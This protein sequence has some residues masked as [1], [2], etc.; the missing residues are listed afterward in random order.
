MLLL[1]CPQNI[2][3]SAYALQHKRLGKIIDS[4]GSSFMSSLRILK[5]KNSLNTMVDEP[6]F[7]K[8]IRKQRNQRTTHPTV[9]LREM[10]WSIY[11]LVCLTAFQT[12]E[13]KQCC[14]CCCWLCTAERL[15][16]KTPLQ[17]PLF[18]WSWWF[19]IQQYL[20][21]TRTT[22]TIIR[23]TSEEQKLCHYF[24]YMSSTV[25]YALSNYTQEWNLLR[26]K[27]IYL[28]RRL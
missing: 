8:S 16:R 21:A 27:M 2:A 22:T 14:C 12:K 17:K 25:F 6:F 26:W 11:C 1:N 28:S 19:L 18:S 5:K 23:K 13:T 3:T 4:L 15:S 20:P 7:S 10:Q 9:P 24:P